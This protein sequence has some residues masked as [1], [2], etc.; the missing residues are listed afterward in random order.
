MTLLLTRCISSF[1]TTASHRD[2]VAFADSCCP[3]DCCCSC[4]KA[5]RPSCVRRRVRT[6]RRV[7]FPADGPMPRNP[8]EPHTAEEIACTDGATCPSYAWLTSPHAK[9]NES[10]KLLKALPYFHPLPPVYSHSVG[11]RPSAELRHP[12][13]AHDA[14]ADRLPHD[15]H[16]RWCVLPHRTGLQTVGRYNSCVG[17]D[18]DSSLDGSSASADAD[19]HQ[20]RC[21]RRSSKRSESRRISCRRRRRPEQRQRSSKRTSQRQ[22]SKARRQSEL[23]TAARCSARHQ[24]S[25]QF[26]N[27]DCF[28]ERKRDESETRANAGVPSERGGMRGRGAPAA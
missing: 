12:L 26:S 1:S 27:V 13:A 11:Y 24:T 14:P 19:A 10:Q 4:R 6:V 20:L 15:H 3:D 23:A 2:P 8:F 7:R 25:G 17:E 18:A 5:C 9:F 22:R 16:L 28:V 21:E